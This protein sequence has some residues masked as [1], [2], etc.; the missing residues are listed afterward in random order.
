[1]DVLDHCRSCPYHPHPRPASPAQCG[2]A[3][4]QGVTQNS[5][6]RR[7]RHRVRPCGTR[8]QTV[9]RDITE[10]TGTNPREA[11]NTACAGTGSPT[12]NHGRIISC[13]ARVTVNPGDFPGATWLLRRRRY[14]AHYS[15]RCAC[16][17]DCIGRAATSGVHPARDRT[18]HDSDRTVGAHHGY[19][20]SPSRGSF[21]SSPHPSTGDF[22]CPGTAPRNAP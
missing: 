11:G 8:T 1:M 12:C 2:Q 14:G 19:S 9:A 17:H 15:A 20:D 3:S 7:K 16:R 5:R 13:P 22:F 10:S 18:I 6:T 21:G 4:A